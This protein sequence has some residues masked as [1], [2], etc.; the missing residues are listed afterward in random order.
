VDCAPCYPEQVSSSSTITSSRKYFREEVC[1]VTKCFSGW[2]EAF[3][4]QTE[5]GL[6]LDARRGSN[7]VDFG[8]K[9]FVPERPEE[10]G[11]SLS[12]KLSKILTQNRKAD[13]LETDPVL[14]ALQIERNFLAL[15]PYLSENLRIARLL[16]ELVLHNLGLP[17][18][19]AIRDEHPLTLSP[20]SHEE[21]L[22]QGMEVHSAIL[23]ACSQYVS[24]VKKKRSDFEPT[25]L[26]MCQENKL[27]DRCD[28]YLTQVR[29][30]KGIVP[31]SV[32]DCSVDWPLEEV[33]YPGC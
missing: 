1:P 6:F 33:T 22:R 16:M 14:E 3:L 27:P 2:R 28:Y 20:S 26:L 13:E 29:V 30:E 21:L 24:C 25:F 31:V 5:N 17:S 9:F 8:R 19:L 11:G 12:S 7:E 23:K 10:A 4:K 18:P 32:C 15:K